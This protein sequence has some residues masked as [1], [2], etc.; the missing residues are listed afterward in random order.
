MRGYN[1]RQNGRQNDNAKLF[2]RVGVIPVAIAGIL[3]LATAIECHAVSP[4][5]VPSPRGLCHSRTAQFYG[6]GGQR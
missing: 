4:G 6:S 2:P 5:P 1:A 3:A